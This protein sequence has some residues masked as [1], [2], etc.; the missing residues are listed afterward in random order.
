MGALVGFAALRALNVYGDPLPWTP[1]KDT[2]FTLMSFI[3]TTKYPPSLLFLLMTLGMSLLFL[4][5]ADETFPAFLR[6]AIH[7]GRA[8]LLYF[9][10]HFAFI[11]L[12]AVIVTYAIHGSAHWMFESPS[13]DRYPFTPPPGWGFP[14]PIV[15]ALWV[16]VVIVLFWP[17]RK[18]AE[19]KATGRYPW[20]SY[21]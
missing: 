21:F 13:I 20:L 6:P 11:H 8:P 18:V 4:R 19:L 2:L 3:N 7:F 14:L 1:Q 5:W 9:V 17:T 12:L 10:A 16:F 15:Y